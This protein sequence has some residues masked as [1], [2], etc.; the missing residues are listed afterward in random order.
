MLPNSYIK[1]PLL[2]K[3][4]TKVCLQQCNKQWN[5]PYSFQSD[6]EFFL[7]TCDNKEDGRNRK[8]Q[9]QFFLR[10][11]QTTVRGEYSQRLNILVYLIHGRHNKWSH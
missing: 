11:E 8:N 9:K 2:L 5:Y 10:N 3:K 1:I 4:N 7:P 6:Y